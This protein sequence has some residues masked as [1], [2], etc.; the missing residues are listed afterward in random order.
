LSEVIDSQAESYKALV[1]G[2][3]IKITKTGNTYSADRNLTL[4][5]INE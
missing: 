3:S 1:T 2:I 5:K 4:E